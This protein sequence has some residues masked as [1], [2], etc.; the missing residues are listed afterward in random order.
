MC[1]TVEE[2]HW[3]GR[4]FLENLRGASTVDGDTVWDSTRRYTVDLL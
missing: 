4:Q 2:D 3:C 1:A